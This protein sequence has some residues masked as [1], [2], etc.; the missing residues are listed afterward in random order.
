M[1][2]PHADERETKDIHIANVALKDSEGGS[3]TWVLSDKLGECK[4]VA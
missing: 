3:E 2:G 4:L 1:E